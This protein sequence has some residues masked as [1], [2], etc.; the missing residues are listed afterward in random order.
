MLEH[1][2]HQHS[3]SNYYEKDGDEVRDILGV[4]LTF[5]RLSRC[6]KLDLRQAIE[7][8]AKRFNVEK[9]RNI[10][11][12]CVYSDLSE[13]SLMDF[14]IQSLVGGLQY[15]GT[16]CRPDCL[17]A[18]NRI[19]RDMSP[20]TSAL[21]TAAKRIVRYLL[22]SSDIGIEYS[23]KREKQ[24]DDTYTKCLRDA[25]KE[26]Q[27]PSL[28]GFS[29]SDCAGCNVSLKSHSGSIIYHR[30]CPIAWSSRRQS[31]R[32]KS[33]CEAEYVALYDTLRL[34][35]GQTF[36]DWIEENSRAPLLFC[37]NQSTITVANSTLPTK[38]TKHFLLRFHHVKEHSE[39]IA[40][41]PTSINKSDPLT[42]PMGNPLLVF[43]ASASSLDGMASDPVEMAFAVYSGI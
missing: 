31:I 10:S 14:P 22:H 13:G 36:M 25:G 9:G 40:Y 38:N 16:M 28:V 15:I 19:A 24:F 3:G 21:V 23:P 32:A 37:D 29:D 11:T 34:I 17:F 2:A 42:K 18:I 6:M 41:V 7:K 8:L 4:R 5:N 39:N 35:E 12:P 1:N 20:C 27:L 33:T 26:S 43:M 30:G